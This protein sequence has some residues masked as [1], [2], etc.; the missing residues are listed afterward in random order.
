MA[1]WGACRQESWGK[2]SGLAE[3]EAGKQDVL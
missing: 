2:E 3:A 1:G